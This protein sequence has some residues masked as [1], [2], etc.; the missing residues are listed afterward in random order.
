MTTTRYIV[1]FW[2][3]S[4]AGIGVF[5]YYKMGGFNAPELSIVNAP[6]YTIVGKAYEGRM[7]SKEFGE[8]FEEADSLVKTG[9]VKGTSCGLF[10]NNPAS[11]KD[12]VKAFVGVMPNAPVQQV[13]K[14][15]E[16]RT[17]PAR[18][19]AQAHVTAHYMLAPQVY[20]KLKEYADE[21]G[22]KINDTP[23]LEIYKSEDE[24]IIQ[25]PVK[26]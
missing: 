12:V 25:L 10:A 2:A 4:I 14:G 11:G 26:E 24:I 22:I 16:L 1:L 21:K 6:A 17:E 8:L 7:N 20:P 18:K 23:A 9:T 5:F 3:L 13:P 19:V 15:F